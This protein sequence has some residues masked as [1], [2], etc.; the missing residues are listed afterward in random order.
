MPRKLEILNKGD[1]FLREEDR[2][3]RNPGYPIYYRY[4]ITYSIAKNVLSPTKKSN[5]AKNQEW[6]EEQIDKLIKAV[7]EKK[8]Y[9]YEENSNKVFIEL[10]PFK[11]DSGYVLVDHTDSYYPLIFYSNRLTPLSHSLNDIKNGLDKIF[12]KISSLE[13][14]ENWTENFQKE[15]FYLYSVNQSN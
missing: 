10:C 3:D 1:W 8:V 15:L 5:P 11:D 6:V 4:A 14:I 12:N 9:K 2:G 7:E 13:K